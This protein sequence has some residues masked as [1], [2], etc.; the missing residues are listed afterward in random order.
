MDPFLAGEI[1]GGSCALLGMLLTCI[2]LW[3]A[4]HR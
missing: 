4:D 3:L 1:V 2:V